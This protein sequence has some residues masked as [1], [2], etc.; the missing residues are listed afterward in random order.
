[1][2]EKISLS[3]SQGRETPHL[4]LLMDKMDKGFQNRFHSKGNGLPRC[5]LLV[6]E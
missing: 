3:L 1:M 4:V 6:E 5:G 2:M